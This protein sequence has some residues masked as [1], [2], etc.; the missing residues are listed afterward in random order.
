MEAQ[1]WNVPDVPVKGYVWEAQNPRAA[2]LLMHGFG[3]YAHRYI[4]KYHR[5]IPAL[6]ESGFT[7]YAYDQRGHGASAGKRAVADMNVLAADHL[8]AR[9]AL[10]EQPLP[11]FLFG[12]SMGG[13]I[14]AAS[15]ARDPSG[16]SGVILS[17]P[18]LLV[19]A[20]ES[21]AIKKVAPLLAKVAPALAV[22]GLPTTHLS[23]NAAEVAAYEADPQIYHGKVPALSAS[24]ML[25]LSARLW[26]QYPNWQLPTL[27][28][29]GSADQVTDPSGSRRFAQ[30]IPAADK[31][32]IEFA[33]GY[34]EL[35]NDKP[36]AEVLELILEWL[37]AR[38]S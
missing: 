14:S 18:A 21:A 7:V 3:E 24:S 22:T 26:A 37:R 4:E 17:S 6:L 10:R 2:V 23:R 19:G 16:I 9:A 27:I 33:G 32:H 29:H 15:A 1:S 30:T 36:S 31:T 25:D 8:K 35:L 20:K 5:L 12:H 11:L 13:L 28:F 34:H 38:T